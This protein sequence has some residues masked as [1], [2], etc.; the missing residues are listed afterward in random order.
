MTALK[1]ATKGRLGEKKAKK[2]RRKAQN[3]KKKK[4]PQEK[5]G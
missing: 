4:S 3:S 2:Y 1:G 5:I